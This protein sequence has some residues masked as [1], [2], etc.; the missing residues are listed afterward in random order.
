MRTALPV[1][2][3]SRRWARPSTSWPS[4]TG[5][6]ASSRRPR[7][8]TAR[9]ASWGE[10]RSPA[11]RSC[12]WPRARSMRPRRRSAAWST[13]PRIRLT[14][15][16]AACRVRRDHARRKRRRRRRAPPRTS[17]RRSPLELD[18]P[19][20][21]AVATHAHGAV[22]LAE[23]RRPSRPRRAAPGV[24][25]LAGPRGAVRSARGPGSSS[26]S[27]AGTSGTKTARRWSSTRRA[28]SF[29]S[30]APRRTSPG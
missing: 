9:P 3:T 29:G 12:G 10:R 28:E 21:R 22:L 30:W 13:R 5:C 14:R 8:R 26:G 6:A 15:A 11:W 25:G 17:C 24:D 18:A 16:K 27:P 20:L 7:R 19:F 23:G 2:R 1:R 4:S